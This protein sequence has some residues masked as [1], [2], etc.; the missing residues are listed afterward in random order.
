MSK[1]IYTTIYEQFTGLKPPEPKDHKPRRR[2]GYG[3]PYRMRLN[4][5]ED[6]AQAS[7]LLSSYES[8]RTVFEQPPA[9]A[10]QQPVKKQPVRRFNTSPQAQHGNGNSNSNHTTSYR[11]AMPEERYSSSPEPKVTYKRRRQYGSSGFGLA[12][13]TRDS[14]DSSDY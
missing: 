9:T 4:M 7:D 13:L 3:H 12:S 1:Y 10:F 5:Q 6:D 8:E 11:P 14:S 2:R